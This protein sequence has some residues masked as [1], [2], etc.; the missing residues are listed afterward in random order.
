MKMHDRRGKLFK[1]SDVSFGL[2][3]PA[4]SLIALATL[5]AGTAQAQARGASAKAVLIVNDT[6]AIGAVGDALLSLDEA[7]RLSNG[8]LALNALSA[9]ERAQVKGAPGAK[10]PDRI[11]MTAGA[12]VTVPKGAAVSS[13]IGNEGDTLDGNGATLVSSTPGKGVGISISSSNFFLT[14][15]Q[16]RNFD[17]AVRVDFGGRSLRNISLSKLR[18]AG[19]DGS[20]LTASALSS[21]GSLKGLQVTD[22]SFEFD[23]EKGNHVYIGSAAGAVGSAAITNTLLEDAL[24]SR[25]QLKGGAIGMYI[26][27]TLSGVNTTNATTRKVTVSD[28]RFTGQS[29]SPVNL[30]GALPAV[31]ATHS[32]VTLENILVTGNQLEAANWGI[33]MGHETFGFGIA[34]TTAKG[35]FWRNISI[36]NNIVT[37]GSH[38]GKKAHC[39]TLET[40]ADSPGDTASGNVIEN[41]TISGNDV[42]GCRNAADGLGTGII[43]YAG[44]NLFFADRDISTNTG[45]IARN[46]TIKNNRVENSDRGI[47]V[48]GGYSLSVGDKIPESGR[49]A[50]A[51]LSGAVSGNILSGVRITGN[52]LKN[53][54]TG[55]RVIGGE[56]LAGSRVTGNSATVTQIVGNRI[57]GAAIACE[58]IANAGAATGNTLK[59]NCPTP[60]R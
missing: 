58:T 25:N 18:L 33:W 49:A 46:L 6:N 37:L 51:R 23:G 39:I 53:N 27:G 50:L 14:G 30:A 11:T 8:S 3:A 21:N 22:S 9:T 20:L 57:S 35:S 34:P 4:I 59:A 28:N 1:R 42:R 45:N 52:E 31:G 48:G 16:A 47:V 7:I 43:V 44:R 29:D 13:L 10:S 26:H 56:G 15:F 32:N 24:F 41:V 17:P 2:A 36:T 38:P 12:T 5:D 19:S 40:G 54:R 60:R 55:I